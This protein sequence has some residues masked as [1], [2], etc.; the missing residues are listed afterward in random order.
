MTTKRRVLESLADRM[1]AAEEPG[2]TPRDLGVAAGIENYLSTLPAH[3]QRD[4]GRLILLFEYLPPLIIF[5]LSTFSRLEPS[6]QD[7]YIEA[8]G[9]SRFGM[10]R[11][12]FRVLKNLCVSA[13]YQN[14]ASWNA[15]GYKA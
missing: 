1:I 12:G 9:T 4:L 13:Y 11:T 10:L 14:P 15:I 7:I 6:G 3:L 8:W 5:R 2:V